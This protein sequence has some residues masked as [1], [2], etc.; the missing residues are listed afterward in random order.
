M[1]NNSYTAKETS[2]W[3]FIQENEIEI[4]IIQRDYAQGRLGKESLRKNFLN[5]LKKALD[6]EKPYKD[7]AMKMDFVYGSVEHEKMNP[8]DGQQRLTTLWL[9]HWYIALRA[10][11][12]EEKVAETLNKFTYETRISSRVF[13]CNLCNPKYFKGFDGTNVVGFITRQTWFYS[14]WKQDPTIQSMLR[15]LGGTKV[16]NKKG[17]DIVDGIEELFACPQNCEIKEGEK[18]VIYRKFNE[19]W[20]KLT[21]DNCPIVFYHLPLKDFGLS[22]DLY[23]K[24]N[25]RGKQLTSFENFKADLV[26]YITEQSDSELLDEDAKMSWKSLLDEREGIPIK[27]DTTWTDFFWKSKSVDSKIDEIYFAFLNRFFWDKLFM[28]K[29]KDNKYV[30]DIGKGDETSTQENNNL[31]YKYLN[32]SEAGQNVY[33]T[34]ISYK[35]LDVYKFFNG[36]IPYSVFED[37]QIVLNRYA[38]IPAC[39]WDDS[40]RFIPAYEN[41]SG[42]NIEIADTSGEKILKVTYLNQVQRIVFHAVCKYFKEG[43]ADETSLKRWMRVVWNLVS[44]EDAKGFQIRSTSAM[45]SAME[46]IDKLDSHN[47]Y[48]CLTHFTDKLSD[49][50]FDKRCKEEIAKAKQILDEDG[51]L[52]QYKGFHKKEDGSIYQTWEEIIIEAER[53][54]FFKG[55]IRF[56]FQNK[57]GETTEDSWYEFNKK[58]E[59]AKKY[60]DKNGLKEDFK[61][62]VTKA[63]VI[64]CNSWVNQLKEKQIFNPNAQTWKYILCSSNWI[65]QIHHILIEDN[66]DKIIITDSLSDEEADKYIKPLFTSLPYEEFINKEPNGRF[67]WS[68]SRLG[69]YKPYGRDAIL[70]D[71]RD[72]RRNG[73]LNQLVGCIDIDNPTIGNRFWWG[74]DIRFKFNGFYFVFYYNNT[75]CLMNDNWSGKK[76]KD[77]TKQDKPEN[78]FYYLIS[79]N[80]SKDSFLNKLE[81]LIAQA[82]PDADK[83]VCEG[84]QNKICEITT[85]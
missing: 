28:Y 59:K 52:R 11:K 65:R 78:N 74:W 14:A 33:D 43:E 51:K 24:M 16:T 12:L 79:E 20:Y 77:S 49:S 8:L 80:E 63:L 27:M 39:T 81:C 34:T 58:W 15:M 35:E 68:G 64:Q 82:Y 10:G 13:C 84:C 37:L 69:Y 23:I 76:L 48:N 53:T 61:V 7:K 25:A 72:F 66:L 26:D 29:K 32:N 22:D 56:L 50:E 60:F 42:N 41:D 1:S 5:D 71:W 67:K 73:L 45:R 18:C 70:F 38:E 21:G 30:L 47:V 2:F 57:N 62:G 19:Y 6:N 40:F 46:F 31:S 85:E 83:H 4:P 3:N 36:E 75:I 44:G 54:A 17:E 55:S 9:V